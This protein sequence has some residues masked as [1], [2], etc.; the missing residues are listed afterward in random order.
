[1]T[2]ARKGTVTM[3]QLI[4]DVTSLAQKMSKITRQVQMHQDTMSKS[5]RLLLADRRI[6][7]TLQYNL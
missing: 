5:D 7:R 1:M 2:T 4:A 6:S 3:Y